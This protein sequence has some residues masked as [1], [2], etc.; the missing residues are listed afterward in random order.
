M[1]LRR[2]TPLVGYTYSKQ[3]YDAQLAMAVG[4]VNASTWSVSGKPYSF[5]YRGAREQHALDAQAEGRF[6]L[7][8]RQHE[9]VVGGMTYR[10]QQLVIGA[11]AEHVATYSGSLLAWDGSFPKPTWGE[12][13]VESEM[14]TRQTGLYSTVRLSLADPLKV[15]LGSRYSV[16]DRDTQRRFTHL[17]PYA[18]VVYDI[19]DRLSL[20]ASYTDI[21][22]PQDALDRNGAYLDPITGKS[23]ELGVKTSTADNR[24]NA[25]FAV[26]DI[27]QNNLAQVDADAQTPDGL[28]QA[29]Y[30]AKGATS[31]GFEFELGGEILPGWNAK[32]SYVHYTLKD[33]NGQQLSTTLPRSILDLF[34]TYRFG[35][36]ASKL[37]IGGGMRYQSDVGGLAWGRDSTG[38]SVQRHSEQNSYALVNLMARYEFTPTTSLQ[39]NLNNVFDKTYL[40]QVAFYSTKSY[41]AP[42][43]VLVTLSHKF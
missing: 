8:G 6:D 42:R 13:Y 11:P 41:G 9:L 2:P 25:S 4:N 19:N 38:T 14:K 18:G 17:T 28:S 40:T 10:Q 32:L 1:G 5:W 39:V 43:N 16:W 35:G 31:K 26:F 34:T 22:Q 23:R 21:F 12:S 15:I 3:S 29:Y 20:Y 27:V 7:L 36:A 30:G 24:L 37:T 33:R